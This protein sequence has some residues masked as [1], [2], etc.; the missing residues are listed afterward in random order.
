MKKVF[1]AD[2]GAGNT[3]FYSV[4][5][6]KRTNPDPKPLIDHNV[7]PSGYYVTDD[8]QWHVGHE[9]SGLTWPKLSKINKMHINIKAI[10]NGCNETELISYFKA[11]INKL[12]EQRR[13]EFEGFD[14][15]YWIIGCP[16]GDE[17]K[18]EKTRNKY[19][20]IFVKAGFGNTENVIIV[21]ESNAALAYYQKTQ[22]AL[23]ILDKGAGLLLLDQGA[24]SLDA[25]YFSDGKISSVGS[26]LGASII[27]KMILHSILYTNEEKYR[28]SR[29]E[30]NL[31]ETIDYVKKL[32][33][34]QGEKGEIFR[35]FLLLK[36][37]DLKE[38]YFNQLRNGTL[39]NTRDLSKEVEI[40]EE[41]EPFVIFTNRKMMQNILEKIPIKSILGEEFYLLQKEAQDEIGDK[42]WMQAFNAFLLKVEQKYPQFYSEC[43]KASI[44]SKKPVILLTGG[45]SMMGCIREAVEVHCPKASIHNDYDAVSAIGKGMAYWA[46]D[47]INAINFKLASDKFFNRT[48]V[49]ENGEDILIFAKYMNDVFEKCCVAIAKDI[50]G[51]ESEAV[52]YGITEWKNYNCSGTAISRK[53]ESHFNN[54]IKNT[55][56]QNMKLYIENQIEELKNQINCEFS[57]ILKEYGLEKEK[58]LTAEDKVFL[59][60]TKEIL[61]ESLSV[62]SK[63]VVEHYKNELNL[64]K[65]FPDFSKKFFTDDRR[66]YY[67]SNEDLIK[68]IIDKETNETIECVSDVFYHIEFGTE[69]KKTIYDYFIFEGLYDILNRVFENQK[70][71]L[72]KLVLEEYIDL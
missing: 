4:V 70:Q 52:K 47:K 60:D 54:W 10:P 13:Y 25:T 21:P 51:E 53:I 3:C 27:E 33:N 66:N 49:N 15:I 45:G 29:R 23:E 62:I 26:Y 39:S 42:T 32:Y 11:W 8:S 34:L 22:M 12:K 40:D 14:E 18:T 69:E 24:Y 59:S 55:E 37:R 38:D 20:D 30:H 6:D 44:Q 58:I 46:P 1:V 50:I 61:T 64:G 56:L 7:V 72:G 36:T 68:K 2:F 35:T 16:T 41:L 9:L 67:N 48:I 31:P 19:R 57:N 28:I 17:W 43:N 71:L 65:I 63:I 5:V